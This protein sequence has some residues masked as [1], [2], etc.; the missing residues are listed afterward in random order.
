MGIHL[1]PAARHAVRRAIAA[2]ERT[3]L[4]EDR[5]RRH[6]L[7]AERRLRAERPEAVAAD[8][9]GHSS[10]DTERV[11]QVLVLSGVRDLEGVARLKLGAEERLG[12]ARL[13][14]SGGRAR[15]GRARRSR[16]AFDVVDRLLIAEFPHALE[17]R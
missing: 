11:R 17:A 10:R 6:P 12:L 14:L 16:R 1:Q 4:D 15:A 8:R 3:L 7:L 5:P 2:V 13:Q 9:K